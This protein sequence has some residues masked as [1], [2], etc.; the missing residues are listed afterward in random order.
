LGLAKLYESLEW[1]SLVSKP[2]VE[3]LCRSLVSKP[4]VE[5]RVE[6]L[7]VERSMNSVMP[8]LEYQLTGRATA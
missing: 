3:A 4:C 5:A 1:R 6:L 8:L 7:C 2:C